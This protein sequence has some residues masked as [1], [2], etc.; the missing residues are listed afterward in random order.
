MASTQLVRLSIALGTGETITRI[1]AIDPATLGEQANM[2]GLQIV[3][4]LSTLL[5]TGSD[6]EVDE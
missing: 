2:I 1:L 6:T 4:M 5:P 3:D